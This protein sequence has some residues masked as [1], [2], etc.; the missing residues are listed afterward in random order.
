LNVYSIAGEIVSSI[1]VSEGTPFVD[2][3]NLKSGIY[4]LSFTGQNDYYTPVK[5]IKE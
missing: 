5:W 3:S 2:L 1:Q 4:T